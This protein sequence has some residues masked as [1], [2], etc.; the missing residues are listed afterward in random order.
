MDWWVLV[1]FLRWLVEL[2]RQNKGGCRTADPDMQLS[3]AEQGT[4]ALE[5]E[6]KWWWWLVQLSLSLYQRFFVI[7]IGILVF[8]SFTASPL[9]LN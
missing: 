8:L 6:G 4:M 7:F 3:S 2:K 1:I 9:N 5:E